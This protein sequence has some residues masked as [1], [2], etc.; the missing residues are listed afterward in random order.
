MK[1]REAW[2]A[3]VHEVAK[4]CATEQQQSHDGGDYM[5]ITFVQTH[6]TAHQQV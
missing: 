1:D 3:A 6:R 4:N 5:M 2:H